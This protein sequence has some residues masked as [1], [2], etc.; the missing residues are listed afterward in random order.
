MKNT[1]E[2]TN[3]QPEL[4]SDTQHEELFMNN[5]EKKL[6]EEKYK[7]EYQALIEDALFSYVALS[8]T[9]DYIIGCLE[10]NRDILKN[11]LRYKNQKSSET[12][13][14]GWKIGLRDRKVMVCECHKSVLYACPEIEAGNPV[15]ITS[16]V[17]GDIL[18]IERPDEHNDFPHL[19]FGGPAD[20]NRTSLIE[21]YQ[22]T[23]NKT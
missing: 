19:S 16:I 7:N 15:V 2:K 9:K 4:A 8:D 6:L 12:I 3:I 5:E 20:A 13:V 17:D 23:K 21:N 11:I 22:P 1:L 14:R 18:Y 10:Y